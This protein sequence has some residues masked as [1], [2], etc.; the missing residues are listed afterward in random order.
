MT[1]RKNRLAFTILAIIQ[2]TLIF[3]ISLIMIPL[4]KIAS[5]F[6]LG[7][8]QLLLL[9]VAYGLP[10]SGLLLFG[11]RLTDRYRGR[12]MLVIGLIVFGASS[13]VAAFSPSFEVLVSMR[14]AQ[15]IGGALTAP[16]AMAV[17][18]ALFPDSVA[19]GRA[20]AIWGG[21]S[22][23][24]SLVG[25][26]ASGILTTWMSW[27][28]MF[29]VPILVAIMGLAATRGLLPAG[30]LENTARRPGL[31]PLGAILA[32]LGIVFASYGL[33]AAQDQSW[34]SSVVWGPLTVGLVL[35]AAFLFVERRVR[36]P[37][38]PPGFI[39]DRTRFTGMLGMLLAAASSALI[40]FI[41]SLYLQQLR[42]WSSF[43]TAVGFLPFAVTLIAA[44]LAVPAL[45]GRF[46]ARL[47]TVAGFILG[48]VGLGLLAGI[49]RD[50]AYA[51]GLLP[52][53]ILLAA[54]VSLIFSG[55]AVLSTAN[56]PKH[57]AGLA[58][59]VMNTSMELGPT[60]GLAIL[61]SV[62]SLQADVVQGYAWAFGT[63]GVV[64]LFAAVAAIM[65]IRRVP[66]GAGEPTNH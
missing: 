56:V 62:A 66:S 14:F 15:G 6:T 28:W 9:Q 39:L 17:L 41:L 49:D 48:A 54:S 40:Q 53:Q 23:L 59:G 61:M 63:A 20:M 57:Q 55:A 60:V 64:Y 29:V 1:N 3:T 7:S 13:L 58:G 11:G 51:S 16:A 47:V 31:D 5:E 43:T 42:N 24:G 52:G 12:R 36:D 37:L 19:F 30:N 65:L 18:R 38:L 8:S 4:P 45:V 25:F 21:V 2:A 35:L 10:F 27:R 32:T 46:G 44:N 50:T 22:V 26:V 34:A 33:V